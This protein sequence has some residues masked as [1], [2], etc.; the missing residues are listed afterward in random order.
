MSK[1][2]VKNF[3]FF[4]EE[5]AE[6]DAAHQQ[7]VFNFAAAITSIANLLNAVLSDWTKKEQ[8]VGVTNLVIHPTDML[9]RLEGS[10]PWHF[11]INQHER[12]FENQINLQLKVGC[13]RSGHSA[14]TSATV[15]DRV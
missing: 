15:L 3:R 5:S 11:S 10:M 13:P 8:N 4:R 12:W 7:A 6:N 9:S 2:W 1:S 14:I